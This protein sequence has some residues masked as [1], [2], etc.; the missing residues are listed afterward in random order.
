MLVGE[1]PQTPIKKNTERKNRFMK[2]KDMTHI[3]IYLSSEEYNALQRQKEYYGYSTY[4]DVIRNFIHHGLFINLD[5]SHLDD[6]T[7]QI[8]KI[9]V[10]INQIAKAV[11]ENHSVTSYQVQLLKKEFENLKKSVN[12][13]IIDKANV[14]KKIGSDFFVGGAHGN[15]Q[16]NQ[17]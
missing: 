1:Y 15:L 3:G 12:E 13:S 8:H 11:N 17:D 7:E 14:T 9:G 6:Y 16:D 4:S 5:Y 10:N 2:R